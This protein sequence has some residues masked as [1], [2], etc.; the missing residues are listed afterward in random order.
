M[1]KSLQHQIIGRALE[2]LS[3][4]KHWT[5]VVVARMADG[6]PC[7]CLDPLAARFCAIG[8]LYRAAGELLGSGG[9]ELVFK[10][11]KFVLAANNRPRD[12]LPCINDVEGRAGTAQCRRDAGISKCDGIPHQPKAM[13][14]L[15][16]SLGQ[17]HA[18]DARKHRGVAQSGRGVM[19]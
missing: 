1:A 18:A 8:A 10:A 11:E 15:G 6:E 13:D 16:R 19:R 5:R 9:F 14:R 4:E 3:D 17:K 2:I 7:G 12:S